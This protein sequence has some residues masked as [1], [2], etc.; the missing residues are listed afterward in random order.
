MTNK[1]RLALLNR[2][3][4]YELRILK[5]HYDFLTFRRIKQNLNTNLIKKGF[6]Q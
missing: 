4:R 6:I 5:L 3:K 2:I 1:Q